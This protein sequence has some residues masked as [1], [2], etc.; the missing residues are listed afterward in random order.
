M[1]LCSGLVKS[2]F[3]IFII[4]CNEAKKEATKGGNSHPYGRI[5]PPEIRQPAGIHHQSITNPL[6][7]RHPSSSP[8]HSSATV[9]WTASP[10][11]DITHHHHHRVPSCHCGR[12]T[13]ITQFIIIPPSCHLQLAAI[14]IPSSAHQMPWSDHRHFALSIPCHHSRQLM[15]GAAPPLW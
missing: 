10:P 8:G 12:P 6:Y 15:E 5:T 14:F 7:N 3:H 4:I 2:S 13:N 11:G 9:H 1:N